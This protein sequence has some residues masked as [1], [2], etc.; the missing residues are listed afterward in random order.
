MNN[1]LN[2]I[3]SYPI[4]LPQTQT[5]MYNQVKYLPQSIRVD[6]VCEVTENL[7]QFDV[8]NLHV[9]GKNSKILKNIEKGLRHYSIRTKGGYLQNLAKQLN[10]QLIHSHFGNIG[11]NNQ[12]KVDGLGIKHIVTYYGWD[13]T[14]LPAQDGN[15]FSRYKD[16][17]AKADRF[18]CEGPYMASS[19]VKMG[20]DPKK[21]IV[22]HLGV[23]TEKL[24]YKPRKFNR[25]DVLRVL[26]AA[27]FV[28]K[29][30][31]PY[32]LQALSKL[33]ESTS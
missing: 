2:V 33:R 26:I 30:G 1:I 32:A 14:M 6:V 10:T 12:K 8:P 19:L 20:C 22:H 17:F 3:H 13:V 29:K 31:I 15:W 21:I 24:I 23:E 7:D 11:W 18:L 16:L 5:W 9:L 25:G 28:E 4:W 27:S